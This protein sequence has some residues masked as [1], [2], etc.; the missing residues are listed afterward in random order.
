[1]LCTDDLFAPHFP[2]FHLKRH[3]LLVAHGI[4]SHPLLWGAVVCSKIPQQSHNG[5]T[6]HLQARLFFPPK[7]APFGFFS[8]VSK[9]TFPKE[10]L[11]GPHHAG[12]T[13]SAVGRPPETQPR[14]AH[15]CEANTENPM[16]EL[17]GQLPFFPKCLTLPLG[18][19][20]LH[21]LPTQNQ[22]T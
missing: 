15:A 16:L 17:K 4:H 12:H 9:E 13:R 6:T 19:L 5:N 21:H 2:E 1:M 8:L 10:A 11:H 14:A 7:Y 3:V 18:L 20:P 22:S